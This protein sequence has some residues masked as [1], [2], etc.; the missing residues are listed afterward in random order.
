MRVSMAENVDPNW[1]I[2]AACRGADRRL[3]F[4]AEREDFEDWRKRRTEALALC[5]TCAVRLECLFSA[6]ATGD[7]CGVRGGLDLEEAV[8][9]H[10]KAM[11]QRRKLT[12]SPTGVAA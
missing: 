5:S 8:H 3:F 2:A 12:P 7:K 11:A 6:E 10:R 9:E 4:R 1:R